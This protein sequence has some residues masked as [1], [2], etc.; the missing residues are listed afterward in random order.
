MNKPSSH[1][2]MAT[3]DDHPLHTPHATLQG[4]PSDITTKLLRQ[5]NSNALTLEDQQDE[6]NI[7]LPH[8]QLSAT[9]LHLQQQQDSIQTLLNLVNSQSTSQ[10]PTLTYTSTQHHNK[11]SSKPL[12]EY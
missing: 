6:Q 4:F 5:L 1:F 12:P 10:T 8:G 7:Q 2:T 9:L 11:A 3:S